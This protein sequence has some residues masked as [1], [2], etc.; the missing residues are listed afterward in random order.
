MRS[1]VFIPLEMLARFPSVALVALFIISASRHSSVMGASR[2]EEGSSLSWADS[3]PKFDPPPRK[4]QQRKVEKLKR[5]AER[6]KR[7]ALES[8]SNLN[9]LDGTTVEKEWYE[10]EVSLSSQLV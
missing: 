6:A 5:R 1:P 3:I 4:S 9:T 8:D 10:D 2:P 7:R